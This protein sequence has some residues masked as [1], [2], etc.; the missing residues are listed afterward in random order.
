M[1]SD[2]RKRVAIL[3]SGGDAPGMNAVVRAA[4][5]A[6]LE[7]GLEVLAVEEGFQGLVEGGD[8]F[9]RMA[10][11]DV[12]GILPKGGTVIGTARCPAFR[13]REG[14]LAA[15]RNV[16]RERIEGLVVVGGDGSLTGAEL[17]RR[18]WPS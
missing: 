8:R 1:A 7:R 18:E 15:A 6:A 17:F 9:R 12:G 16:A 2:G 14:R 3:T 11:G 4:V 5:R 13:T 10:W